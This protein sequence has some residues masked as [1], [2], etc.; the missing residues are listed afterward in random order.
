MDAIVTGATGFLGRRVVRAL[1]E[2]GASVRCLVRPSSDLTSLRDGL[3]A[4]WR[5]VDCE[6]ISLQDRHACRRALTPNC[7]IYHVAAGLTGSCSTLFL[8]TVV[9]TRSLIEAA[10]EMGARRFVL[11]SSLGV[12][13]AAGL[14]RW[15][16]VAEEAPLDP[17]PHRRDPY[18][19]SKIMQEQVAWEAHR[20]RGLPLVVVRPGVLFG[21]GRGLISGRLGLQLGGVLIRMGGRRPLPYTYVDNCAAA[22]RQAGL[23][24]GIEGEAFNIIDEDVPDTT[25]LL[26][27]LRRRTAKPRTLTVPGWSVSALSGLYEWYSR[28]SHGQ[29]PPVITRYRS[30]SLW[31]PLRYS[32]EKAKSRLGWRATVSFEA[33]F[34][35]TLQLSAG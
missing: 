16:V 24:P 17:Q 25:A 11:V 13:A 6:R 5:Q 14:K 31:R 22:I 32:N 10:L 21:P 23:T 9:P 3:G 4:Y 28:R 8:N 35:Q 19:Y 29:L 34:E 2:D 1:C 15:S 18:T 30:A 27:H 20:E 12:Y 26:R 33:A 7:T